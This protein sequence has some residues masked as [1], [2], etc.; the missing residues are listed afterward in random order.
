MGVV[1]HKGATKHVNHTHT[2]THTHCTVLGITGE[3]LGGCW[4]WVGMGKSIICG[5]VLY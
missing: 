1:Y 4:W 2:H 3:M 5:V